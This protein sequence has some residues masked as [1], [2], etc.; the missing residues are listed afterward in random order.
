[1][2][3]LRTKF[4]LILITAIIC[5]VGLATV[6]TIV[7]LTINHSR[8]LPLLTA[9]QLVLVRDLARDAKAD[10][11]LPI[12]EAPV[13]GRPEAD[14]ARMIQDGL[15]VLGSD[16]KV[17]VTR[18]TD[19]HGPVASVEIS[20][21]AWI[22][23]PVLDKPRHEGWLILIGYMALIVAGTA[24]VAVVVSNQVTRPLLLLEDAA[25]A[26]ASSDGNLSPLPETGPAEIRATASAVNRLSQSLRHAMEG[27]MRLVA[28]A[29]HDLRTPMTRMRLRVEFLPEAER[30]LW[31]RDLDELE[32][33]A[34]SAI[35]LVR[36]STD[37]SPKEKL[38]LDGLV[39]RI[40]SEL[41][42]LGL[43]VD[44][45]E[46]ADCEVVANP[47]ALTRAL[48]NVVTNAA[49][50]GGGAVL[51]LGRD[52][53]SAVLTVE[54]RGPGIPDDAMG[55]VFEPFFRADPARRQA[56]PGAGLGLAIAKEIVV[57]HGGTITLA[58]RPGGGL[59][60]RLTFALA[61]GQPRVPRDSTD[62]AASRSAAET[63]ATRGPAVQT[64]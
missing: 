1:M 47:L 19:E 62:R 30:D 34:D 57:R 3:S 28:A 10:A 63:S 20:P 32:R 16:L 4:A 45:A 31:L 25:L 22:A 36:E 49:T 37:A 41:G 40:A 42:E 7:V 24:G 43:P 38:R 52:G 54:D 14:T 33:I 64:R 5:V 21:G 29:G 48:R 18:P 60:Q 26:A 17:V 61:A 9:H 50:H 6:I 39:R 13:A 55:R 11:R 27:R 56:V 51:R 23:V 58:N 46:A 59:V 2:K 12:L 53:A 8:R 15:S 35:R 44:L